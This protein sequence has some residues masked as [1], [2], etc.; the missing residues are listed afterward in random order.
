MTNAINF[1]AEHKTAIFLAAGGFGIFSLLSAAL[2][3]AK[4]L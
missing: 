4:G 1:L 3:A 2:E